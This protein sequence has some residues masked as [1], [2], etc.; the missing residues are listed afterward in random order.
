MFGARVAESVGT[1]LRR[2]PSQMGE[3]VV[4]KESLDLPVVGGPALEDLR[5]IMWDRVGLIRTGDK[6]WEARNAVVSME[7]VLG[8]TI[9]GR[10][11]FD[12]ALMMIMAALRRSESRGGHYRADYPEVDPLQENRALVEPGAVQETVLVT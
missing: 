10:N 5:Q 4:P 9:A 3:V 1:S 6:L 11:A 8:R 2:G 7:R 12:L